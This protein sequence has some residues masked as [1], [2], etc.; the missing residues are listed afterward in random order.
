MP[1]LPY[2]ERSKT[3]SY[4]L[5]QNLPFFEN[6]PFT[7]PLFLCFQPLIHTNRAKSFPLSVAGRQ[8]FLLRLSCNAIEIEFLWKVPKKMLDT[9]WLAPALM[10]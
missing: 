10:L 8:L 3:S 9:F 4:F 5:S 2:F 7:T 6:L 1:N